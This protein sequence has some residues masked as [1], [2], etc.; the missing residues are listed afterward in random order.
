MQGAESD[1][2]SH[3]RMVPDGFLARGIVEL[4][5]LGSILRRHPHTREIPACRT[6]KKDPVGNKVA[7]Y[8]DL[9]DGRMGAVLGT[10]VSVVPL[11]ELS[12]ATSLELE[13]G[14]PHGS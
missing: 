12:G 13:I 5:S 11:L 9:R 2:E 7:C 6:D 10:Y 8:H 4:H 1:T 3:D 14:S